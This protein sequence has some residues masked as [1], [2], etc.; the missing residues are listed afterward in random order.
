MN[1]QNIAPAK[2][3]RYRGILHVK[4]NNDEGRNS[5]HV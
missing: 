3:A 2:V 4:H 5:S 1:I